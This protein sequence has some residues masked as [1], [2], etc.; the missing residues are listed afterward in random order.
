MN[1]IKL[2]GILCIAAGVA[3]LLYGSFSYTKDTEVIKLG[4]VELSVKEKETVNV[5]MWAGV[6]AI[7]VGGALL[8]AGAKKS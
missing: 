7:V 2:A 5:P 3:G 8:L 1:A 4:P 6:G